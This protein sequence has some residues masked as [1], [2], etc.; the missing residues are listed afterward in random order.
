MIVMRPC[1]FLASRYGPLLA[2]R[3][4]SLAILAWALAV[5]L[6]ASAGEAGSYQPPSSP[7]RGLTIISPQVLELAVQQWH[8]GGPPPPAGQPVAPSRE[9]VQVSVGDKTVEVAALGLRRRPLAAPLRGEGYLVGSHLFLRLAGEVPPEARVEVRV[10]GDSPWASPQALASVAHP[11][12]FGPAIHVNQAGYHPDWPK[13]ALVG[14]YLGSLGEL[15]VGERRFALRDLERGAVVYEG[16][17][18]RH[19]DQGLP[20]SPPPYQE[21]Y[22]A[23]FSSW[24]GSG[25][26]RLEVEGLGASLPFRIEAGVFALLARTLALGMYHQR[27]GAALEPPFTR[28]GHGACHLAPAGPPP[29]DRQED[30]YPRQGP[31]PVDVSGGHHDAG[32]YGKYVI[33]SALT[34]HHLLWAVEALPGV[35]GLDNLGLPES[36]NGIPD[37]LDLAAWELRF[38]A[39]MQDQD[40][41]FHTLLRPRNRPYEVDVLPDQGDPQAV[42]PKSTNASAAA[43]AAL[44]QAGSSPRFR[45]AF[46]K[47]AG[48]HLIQALKGWDF[49]ERAWASHGLEGAYR[50]VFHYGDVF[51]DRD[52][53]LWA[54]LELYLATGQRRFGDILQREWDPLATMNRRWGW[55]R[56]FEGLGCAARSLA[57]AEAT[58]REPPSGL[59]HGLV[60]ACRRE[61]IQ[62]GRDQAEWSRKN[63]YLVSLPDADKRR[64]G[65]AWFFPLEANLDLVAAQTLSP[66]PELQE[67]IAGNLGFSLGANPVNVIFLTGMGPRS[68]LEAVNQYAQNDRRLLPPSGLLLGALQVGFA[69]A[70]RYGGNLKLWNWPADDGPLAYPLYDR[71]GDAFNP[72]TESTIASQA[73][74]LAAAAWLMASTPLAQ[75]PWRASP[76][77]ITGLPAS[78]GAGQSADLRLQTPGLEGPPAWT[79]W[80]GAGLAPRWGAE[81]RLSLEPTGP[82]WLEGEACWPDGRRA[83]AVLEWERAA[84]GEIKPGPREPGAWPKV[85]GV[86]PCFWQKCPPGAEAIP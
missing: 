34:A 66:A 65:A 6:A 44:A 24:R 19:P 11:L 59:D 57:W 26:Y 2:C 45:R 46:P 82:R 20:G 29:G 49:L 83:C 21:V 22:L 23:D 37:L 38:L 33:N 72:L 12:R 85:W 70:G 47:E 3:L 27:C 8:P 81:L 50:K 35:A 79:V 58:G 17:L 40:G 63:A 84:D 39:K 60:S 64:N 53:R 18:N 43:V 67:A 52:E 61:V 48:R 30:L 31:W 71:W 86:N 28:F 16:Q 7:S 73:R 55:W 74:A 14:F 76:A 78:A 54:C 42:F 77:L 4:I 10:A 75:Q 1:L 80:E 68:P 9:Q 25:R 15:P 69:S 62:A 32:D 5:P 36:G 56:L 13:K 41:G 51:G